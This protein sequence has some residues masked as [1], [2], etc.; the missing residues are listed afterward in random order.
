MDWSQGI[1]NNLALHF[2]GVKSTH[3]LYDF[4]LNPQEQA[5][6]FKVGASELVYF[7]GSSLALQLR[8]LEPIWQKVGH[9]VYH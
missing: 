9:E 3:E 8:S 1:P 7:W 6:D 5:A 4:L 2:R